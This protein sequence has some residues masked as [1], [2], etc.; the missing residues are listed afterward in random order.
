MKYFE[1]EAQ[2]SRYGDYCSEYIENK[3]SKNKV[4]NTFNV[5]EAK[6]V[7]TKHIYIYIPYQS[8]F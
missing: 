3:R 5:T 2:N 8:R 4:S 1:Y 7:N 6:P